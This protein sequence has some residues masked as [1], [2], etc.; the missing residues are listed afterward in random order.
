MA[1]FRCIS[2][3]REG[4]CVYDPGRHECPVC[5]SADVVFA[6]GT[7]ELPDEFFEALGLEEQDN[8]GETDKA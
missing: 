5:G 4:E 3:G 7:E 2:C 1:R 8:A 6:L